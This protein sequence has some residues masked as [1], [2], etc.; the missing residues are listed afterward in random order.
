MHPR[1]G[2]ARA[3][4]LP[5][6][7]STKG[8]QRCIWWVDCI[9]VAATCKQ[10][11]SEPPASS[12]HTRLLAVTVF[13]VTNSVLLLDGK[14][15]IHP[16][17]LQ[18]QTQSENVPD[19]KKKEKKEEKVSPRVAGKPY[20]NLARDDWLASVYASF[21]QWPL[22]SAVESDALRARRALYLCS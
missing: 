5:P 19:K 10:D 6:F 20:I 7:F 16:H 3:A 17:L 9:S 22:C 18:V 15:F 8:T 13:Q 21:T 4:N 12:F 11:Q 2:A 1:L 14:C